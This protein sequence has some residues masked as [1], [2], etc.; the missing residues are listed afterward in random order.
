M[1]LI[2]VETLKQ[3]LT[4]ENIEYEDYSDEDLELLLTNKTNEL[5]GYTNLP[6]NATNHKT[7]IRRYNGSMVELDYYPVDSITSLKIG[8][9]EFTDDDYVLDQELGI[10]YFELPVSGMLVCDY[11]S[12]LS[13]EFITNKVNP[14]LI[15]M[16][17]YTLK[18]K[19]SGNG[20]ITSMKEGDVSVNYDKDSSLGNL[21]LSRI[22]NLKSYYSIRIRML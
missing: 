10:L 18:D 7:I 13:D 19:F 12:Q 15:D 17:A 1:T 4:L 20:A 5:I 16:I 11:V 8:D 6:I 9:K 14:L 21:I 2:D 22:N 3:N